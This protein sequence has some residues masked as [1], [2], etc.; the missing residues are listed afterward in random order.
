MAAG[1]QNISC[2]DVGWALHANGIM[3]IL[4]TNMTGIADRP[5]GGE[6]FE[7]CH[8]DSTSDRAQQRQRQHLEQL[9]GAGH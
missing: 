6:Q 2:P 7:V 1:G 5:S 4:G 9:K 3:T 8:P